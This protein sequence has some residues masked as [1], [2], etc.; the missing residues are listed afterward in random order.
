M[1]TE[2]DPAVSSQDEGPLGA[3]YQQSKRKREG[4]LRSP[5][6]ASQQWTLACFVLALAVL[7]RHSVDWVGLKLR[8]LPVFASQALGLKARAIAGPQPLPPGW[9][10]FLTSLRFIS[11]SRQTGAII[12]FASPY[13]CDDE[14]IKCL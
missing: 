12:G 3:L 5:T 2:G 1:V 13:S 10:G 11:L 9:L 7:E 4:T 14:L 6:R 8:D